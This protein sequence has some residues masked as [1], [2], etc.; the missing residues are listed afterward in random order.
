VYFPWGWGEA[1]ELR[2]NNIRCWKFEEVTK[3]K[4]LQGSECSWALMWVELPDAAAVARMQAFVDSYWAEQHKAGRFARARNNRLTTVDRWLV[5]QEVLQNDNRVLVQ[6]AFAFLGV[7]LLNTVG[8]LLAK[9]LNES[10]WS[11]VRRALGASRRDIFAQHF[12]EVGLLAVTGALVGALLSWLGLWGI[13]VMYRATEDAGGGYVAL[14]HF[15]GSSLAWAGALA[16]VATLV[17][18]VYPAWRVGRLSP[19]VCLKTQ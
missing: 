15:D 3:F 8:L 17:A 16:V 14:A 9:F 7:C 18:G 5:E 6:V 19:A 11:G 1:L 2:A 13:R 12:V 10:M 4:A